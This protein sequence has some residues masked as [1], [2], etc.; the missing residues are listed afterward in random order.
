MKSMTYKLA[1]ASAFIAAT[2]TSVGA[3]AQTVL[4]VPFRFY[5]GHSIVPAGAYS[6]ERSGA[7]WGG[8]VTMKNVQTNA[9]FTWTVFS[10]R[11]GAD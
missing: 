4:N 9:S 8:F 11:P 10:R 1:L 5:V 7:P 6:V 3:K 2:F